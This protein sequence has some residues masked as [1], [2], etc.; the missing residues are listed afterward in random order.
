MSSQIKRVGHLAL[1]IKVKYEDVILLWGGYKEKETSLGGS[2]Q[3]AS[4]CDPTEVILYNPESGW[5]IQTTNGQVVKYCID[6]S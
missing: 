6:S 5:T 3:L 2:N 1:C 4:Y